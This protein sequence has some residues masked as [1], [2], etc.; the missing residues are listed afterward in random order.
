MQI[1]RPGADTLL[2]IGLGAIAALPVLATGLAYGITMSPYVT[3]QDLV[4]EQPIPFSH[5]HHV[6]RA[7]LDCRYC[8]TSAEKARFAGLPPTETC[9]TCHSQ[10]F[11]NSE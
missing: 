11:T 7:G 5:E 8:H 1:F 2:R 10:L 4:T 6:G 3:E 9:M